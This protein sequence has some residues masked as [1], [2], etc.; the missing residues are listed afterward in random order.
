MSACCSCSQQT[1]TRSTRS[2]SKG[3]GSGPASSS[4]IAASWSGSI[5]LA[6]RSLSLVISFIRLSSAVFARFT[7]RQESSGNSPRTSLIAGSAS[8]LPCSAR[9]TR[10]RHFSRAC[11]RPSRFSSL[12][13]AG[14][15]SAGYPSG[16]LT[17]AVFSLTPLPPLP[18][19]VP[20]VASSQQRRAGENVRA[21]AQL[22]Q[23]GHE[24]FH[25]LFLFLPC[26]SLLFSP[27][28]LLGV[29]PG[30]ELPEQTAAHVLS[31]HLAVDLPTAGVVEAA[32]FSPLPGTH[33]ISHCCVTFSRLP[34]FTSHLPSCDPRITFYAS[35]PL[36]LTTRSILLL[37]FPL[38]DALLVP[39]RPHGKLAVRSRYAPEVPPREVGKHRLALETQPPA[40]SR[41]VQDLVVLGHA[42]P[43]EICLLHH[44]RHH[45]EIIDEY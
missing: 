41:G 7:R 34:R 27:P 39:D 1:T 25:L 29:H 30:G 8:L 38:F 42:F 10:P 31:N 33:N 5:S 24:G 11:R 12:M 15:D 14:S 45:T 3:E 26:R 17:L 20:V 44:E 23:R 9:S 36:L 18:T 40:Q 35:L 32:A 28:A 37:R 2:R 4:L 21:L 19:V 16:W 43:V 6:S 22:F 13:V